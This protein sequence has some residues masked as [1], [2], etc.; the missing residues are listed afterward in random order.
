MNEKRPLFGMLRRREILVPTWKGWLAILL[1]ISAFSFAV[2]R[3]A[4]GFL[5]VDDPQPGDILVLEGWSPEFTIARALAEYQHHHYREFIVTGGPIEIGNSLIDFKSY[6]ELGA[7]T[8]VKWGVDAADLR[9]VPA[10]FVEKDRSYASGIA[11]RNWLHEHGIAA[12]KINIIG[13]GAHA[14]RTRLVYQLAFADEAKVG[15]STTPEEDFDPAHWWKSSQGFKKIVGELI[16][17]AYTRLFF[18]P[19]KQ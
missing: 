13:N 15:I 8:L 9:V 18:F 12:Q 2:I 1:A 4:Y 16:G 5:A 14:R 19:A 11:V 6:A 17:Y 10:P 7:A 3:G